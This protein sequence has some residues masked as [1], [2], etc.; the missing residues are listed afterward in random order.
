M[1]NSNEIT[2]N[3]IPDP[4]TIVEEP[5]ANRFTPDAAQASRGAGAPEIPHCVRDKLGSPYAT[6]RAPSPMTRHPR[7]SSSARRF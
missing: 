3:N 5:V 4:A 7:D 1:S 2:G 6:C